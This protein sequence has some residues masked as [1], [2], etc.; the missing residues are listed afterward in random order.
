MSLRLRELG[1]VDRGWHAAYC[2]S[3]REVFR[4]AD[5]Q[6]WIEWGEWSDHYRAFAVVEGERIVANASVTRMPLVVAGAAIDACQIGAVFCLPSHRGRGLARRALDA[7]LA[8]CGSAPVLLFANPGV[9]EFYPRFGFAPR[10]EHLFIAEHACAPAGEPAPTL[11]PSDPGVRTRLH[12]LAAQGLVESE[13]FGARDHGRI[14][15]WYC[16]NGFARPLRELDR[17]LL[18]VAGIEGETLH[19]DA[20]LASSEQAL[21]PLLPRIID[22]PIRRIRFG[23]TPDRWWPDARA[24]GIDPEPD[25]FLRGFDPMPPMPHKFPLLAQT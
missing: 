18:L 7:A 1:A 20:V 17:E 15:T 8:H 5:F 19:I 2:S 12:A 6:R 10:D 14:I 21:A 3:V 11:D 25:L 13:R 16:A 24:V 9:R 4:H 22:R 23:F